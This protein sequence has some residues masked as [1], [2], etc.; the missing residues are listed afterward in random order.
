MFYQLFVT[1][2]KTKFAYLLLGS[3][4][5]ASLGAMML[6]FRS[7]R[8]LAGNPPN[9]ILIM[10]D[11]LRAD[12]LS[13]YGYERQ[14]TPFLDALVADEAVLFSQAYSASSWT[15]PS[16]AGLF[17]G[18]KPS[19][20]GIN[21]SDIT[22]S[23][24]PEEKL[25]TE[26]LQ[27]AGYY[28]AGFVSS[29]YTSAR[30]GFSQGFDT[31]QEEIGTTQFSTSADEINQLTSNWLDTV[32]VPTIQ[33]TQPLF[34]FV[35]YF[36]PHTWYLPAQECDIFDPGYMGEFSGELYKDGFEVIRGELIPTVEDVEHLKALYDGE[37]KCWDQAF[38]D[39][40]AHLNSLGL[41]ENSILIFTSDHGEMFGEKGYWLHHTSI[42]EEEI[43]VP[44]LI[45]YP[46]VV[47]AQTLNTPVQSLDILPTLLDWLNQPIPNNLDGSSLVP[48]INNK[49]TTH[50]PI[51]TEMDALNEPDHPAYGYIA[52][53]DVRAVRQEE[54]KYIHNV[55]QENDELYELQP[56][57]IYE[58]E[59]LIEQE[60]T[61]AQSL[62]V[63]L[64]QWFHLPTDH[65]Y[66]PTMFIK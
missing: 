54:W 43:R 57:S 2:V 12:H 52:L 61:I 45:S 25:L 29:W 64:Q 13:A 6:L 31:F 28:T 66:L 5:L 19:A 26:Y 40:W 48:L 63:L 7:E 1:F 8:S 60:P 10:V 15:Y 62:F 53:Y 58:T 21:W 18:R 3:G 9:V 22:S 47:P 38:A 65:S 46:G 37:I 30:F 56:N 17:T 32:W 49:T 23:I 50:R 51:F 27:E 55:G 34:L 33:G 36:D 35:Y 11:T 41:I 4:I 59:N 20:L 44:L 39:L 42:Y 16:N 24:A 14:T